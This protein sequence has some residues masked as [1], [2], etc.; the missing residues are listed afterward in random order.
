MIHPAD[1]AACYDN[2][3]VDGAGADAE[4]GC[5]R[6][7]PG[8]S[9]FLFAMYAG[10]GYALGPAFSWSGVGVF[11]ISSAA[12]LCL[13]HSIGMHRLLIHRSFE[14][15]PAVRNVLLYLGTL[16]GMGGPWSML[17]THDVR[18]WA[19]RQ[20]VCHDFFGHRRHWLRDA[21][22]QMHCRLELARWPRIAIDAELRDLRWLAW[23]DRTGNLQQLPVALAMY[24][25]GGV[26]WVCWGVCARVTVGVTGHW[27]VGHIAHNRGIRHHH[28]RGAAVQGYNVPW[29]S[30]LTF[31]EC[32]HNNHHAF[33]G[34]AK[35]SL[36]RG[37]WDPGWWVLQTLVRLRVARN[38]VLPDALPARV[39]LER[40]A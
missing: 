40:A 25:L 23:L 30:L 1:R 34:S 19:Q 33:P 21:W 29:C 16:V 24:A 31:G 12:T 32:W 27:L 35:L 13:G 36:M 7:T 10:T 3:R 17:R 38:P 5:V 6:W 39:E 15:T 9:L 28:V 11:L 14:T 18:D 4:N 22:W 8:R 37:E 26:S 2:P 20:P